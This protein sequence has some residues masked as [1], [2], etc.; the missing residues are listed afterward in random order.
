[1]PER[2][3]TDDDDDDDEDDDDE[4]GGNGRRNGSCATD[5]DIDDVNAGDAKHAD[6]DDDDA[7]ISAARIASLSLDSVCDEH[8]N[9]D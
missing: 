9:V 2:G 8:F 6:D 5:I 1:M 7:K 3:S 4:A